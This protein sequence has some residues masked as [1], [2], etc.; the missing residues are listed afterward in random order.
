[1]FIK[2][3]TAHDE[4]KIM[5]NTDHIS[6]ITYYPESNMSQIDIISRPD[7]VWVDGDFTF[8]MNYLSG[9]YPNDLTVSYP[10]DPR[11]QHE[12]AIT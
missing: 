4:Q 6:L 11:P 3:M 12:E 1:M 2:M 10:R 7:P 9:L 5:L 8:N